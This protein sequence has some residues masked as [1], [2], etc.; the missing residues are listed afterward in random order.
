MTLA[1]KVALV[2]GA[3]RGAGRGI[4]VELG[5]AGATVYVTGRT[6]QGRPVFEFYFQGRDGVSFPVPGA[7]SP[8]EFLLVPL[9]PKKDRR[10][11]TVGQTGFHSYSGIK[12]EMIVQ[13]EVE[14]LGPGHYRVVPTVELKAGEYCFYF[15]SSGDAA[16]Q[17]TGG[18]MFGFG[19]DASEEARE[20]R[21][22]G[23]VVEF[24]F[25]HFSK[26]PGEIRSEW[27]RPDDPPVRR[28][29][30]FVSGMT[31]RYAMETAVILGFP[32]SDLPAEFP[33]P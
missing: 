22:A 18:K 6:T 4:A 23:R 24:L 26:R 7:A 13:L 25:E 5:A 9:E 33:R 14:K 19:V 29:A 31:D 1:G 30:D 32:E 15:Q 10:E 17:G 11:L 8:A 3:T 16:T 21:R 12:N 20:A 28:A 2:A 27:Q